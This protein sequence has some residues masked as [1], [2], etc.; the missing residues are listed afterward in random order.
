MEEG[1]AA[2]SSGGTERGLPPRAGGPMHESPVKQLLAFGQ[3][4]WLDFIQRSLLRSGEL[5]RMIDE[6]GLR[7]ITSNPV[8]F[9]KAIA[10]THEYDVDIADLAKRGL[11]A[12]LIYE[13]LAIE[14]VRHAADLLLPVYEATDGADGFV[15]LEVSP[16]KANDAGETIAEA[17]HLWAAL[18]RPNVMLKVPGTA[19]GLT[20]LRALLTEGINVNVTLL[21]S[22]KRYR[23]VLSAHLEGL[24][25][26]AAAGRKLSRIASVSSFFLS[27]IDTLV[28]RRL[29]ELAAAGGAR[30]SAAAALRGQAAIASA[31]CAYVAFEEVIASPRFQRVRER[32]ARPQRLLWASTGTKD[33]AYSDVK[34]VEALIGPQTINTMPLDTLK[35]YHDHGRPQPRLTGHAEEAAAILEQLASIGI[36][37]DTVTA[38]LLDE[39][40][41]KFVQPH[42]ALLE[43]LEIARQSALGAHVE[44]KQRE[45]A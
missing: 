15:S 10:Q 43:I 28:D 37:I 9:E 40:I 32:G 1:R 30:A 25:A 19:E 21:F 8:I 2:Q 26:A 39:G 38:E 13:S 24:E 34:Y 45:G 20:A 42:D 31:R 29:D 17:K 11:G 27:R 14:D 41:A 44:G 3:S 35:A 16:H 23:D 6:W 12:E 7:G 36:D 22:V 18:K 4:P 33:A 5:E